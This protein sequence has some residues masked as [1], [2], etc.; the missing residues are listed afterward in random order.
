MCIKTRSTLDLTREKEFSIDYFP[1]KN[2][3]SDPVVGEQQRKQRPYDCVN[4]I[5]KEH[6]EFIIKFQYCDE[7]SNVANIR[8]IKKLEKAKFYIIRYQELKEY[9]KIRP[10]RLA[11]DKLILF[12]C[13]G[14][15]PPE[16]HLKEDIRLYG[17]H[18]GHKH[19]IQNS[20]YYRKQID[21]ENYEEQWIDLNK[22]RKYD[23]LCYAN[24]G[25]STHVQDDI[26]R[27]KEN[28]N[29]VVFDTEGNPLKEE[30]P[31]DLR[32]LY[33]R[34][35]TMEGKK[36]DEINLLELDKLKTDKARGKAARRIL[37]LIDQNT[38]IVAHNIRHDI[39]ILAYYN[40]HLPECFGYI[41]TAKENNLVKLE[42]ALSKKNIDF[43]KLD[44]HHA[45]YDT[46]KTIELLFKNLLENKRVTYLYGE[47]IVNKK[48][49]DDKENPSFY[50]SSS[51]TIC[52]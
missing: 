41:C 7:E 29:F 47:E 21:K 39:D 45:K 6:S 5:V 36:L 40:V 1:S 43:E 27:I 30:K 19:I 20:V 33:A 15:I 44:L 38:I 48:Y 52:L 16:I 13:T 51:D 26:R 31:T 12:V 2:V 28:H 25:L 10:K 42:I 11:D 49:A 17:D 23:E 34:K 50:D 14:N 3:P 4:K 9:I 32:E 35:I 37:E 24:R 8:E 46:V 18:F 22:G